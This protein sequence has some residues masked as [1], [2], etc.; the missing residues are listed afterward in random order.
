MQLGT[1]SLGDKKTY[2][3]NVTNSG[4]LPLTF[5]QISAD[6]GV[7]IVSRPTEPITPGGKGV[8]TV[9]LAPDVGEG[10][11]SKTIHVGSNTE[12]SHMHLTLSADVQ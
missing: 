10:Q 4:N 6:P 2:N 1:V 12:P 8:I 7:I 11:I 5:D 3:Y 9:Q